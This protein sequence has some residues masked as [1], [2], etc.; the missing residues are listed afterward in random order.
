MEADRGHLHHRLLDMGF[1]RN[2]QFMI[3]YT[4]SG[5]LGLSA[6]ILTGSGALRAMGLILSVLIF[7]FAGAKVYA[8]NS[9]C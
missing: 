1:H 4:M 5:I 3:L 9:T 2:K 8:Y 6:V 7:V